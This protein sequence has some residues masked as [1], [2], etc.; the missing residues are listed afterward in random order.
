MGSVDRQPI[1]GDEATE[2]LKANAD[3]ANHLYS[4][5]TPMSLNCAV[6][7]NIPDTIH[8]HGKPI[9]LPELSSVIPIH[10]K[11]AKFLP[12]L[13]RLLTHAGYFTKHPAGPTTAYSLTPTSRLL[14]SDHPFSAKPY[15]LFVTSKS[16]MASWIGLSEWFKTGAD[17]TPFEAANG[18]SLW[19]RTR[20]DI[21]EA[22]AGDS[23][24][25]A[26]LLVAKD[27]EVGKAVF[28]GVASLVDVGGGVGAMAR[29][30]AGAYPEMEC[31]VLDLPQVV[32]GL[33]G[34]RNL[35]FVAGDMFVHVPD[36]DA[37]LL[38]VCLNLNI[39]IVM[40][41]NQTHIFL[42]F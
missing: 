10:P 41:T 19:D 39:I 13:M 28:G 38:K 11:K 7:L 12:Q 26:S 42:Y 30:L 25:V 18:V 31:T 24:M 22:M 34:T 20:E 14:L 17:T 32:E 16:F 29:A 23:R 35:R 1:T 37:V 4:Y 33:V 36:A 21:N 3:F 5:I 9:T 27:E 2:L 40:H 8:R 6:K 15:V